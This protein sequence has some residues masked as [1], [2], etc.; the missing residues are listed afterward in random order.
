MFVV[1]SKPDAFFPTLDEPWAEFPEDHKWYAAAAQFSIDALRDG[2]G[3]H[4]LVIGSPVFEVRTLEHYGWK[5]TYL[6]VRQPPF[7]VAHV[8]G[9][10]TAMPF[11]DAEF[12]AVSSTCVVCHAGM[13]RYGDEVRS[14]G[15][16]RMMAEI[17]RVL[18]PGGEAA[19]MLGPVIPALQHTQTHGI[20]HRIYS[21]AGTAL[22]IKRSGLRTVTQ[23][24][25]QGDWLDTE[26]I[27]RLSIL[28]DEG[29]VSLQHCYQSVHLKKEN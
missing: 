22:L 26:Q 21:L 29:E 7:E 15:D 14:S 20:H 11:A 10:A 25:W 23:G 28:P 27:Q 3:R 1:E 2:H 12:D 13:G 4:C 5:V 18:K 24:I 17:A 8:Q 16:H 9:D 6:D 19:L